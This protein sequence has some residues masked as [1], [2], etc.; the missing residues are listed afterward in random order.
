MPKKSHHGEAAAKTD[1]EKV[2]KKQEKRAKLLKSLT[3]VSKLRA[4]RDR[5]LK[6]E[7]ELKDHLKN[8][9]NAFFNALASIT[10]TATAK[11]KKYIRQVIL[12]ATQK[13]P[14]ARNLGISKDRH[15]KPRL[16]ENFKVNGDWKSRLIKRNEEANL[17]LSKYTSVSK[18]AQSY[19]DS[20][21]K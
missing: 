18:K 5:Y 11:E 2:A 8:S 20:L 7:K 13:N 14:E 4:E 19:L 3:R 1:P 16:K 15:G 21:S 9:P 6:I 10:K 17:D 12:K